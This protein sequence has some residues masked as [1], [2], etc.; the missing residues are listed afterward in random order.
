V[1]GRL[2]EKGFADCLAGVCD[3]IDIRSM[4]AELRERRAADLSA[5]EVAELRKWAQR[6]GERGYGGAF[7]PVLTAIYKVLAAQKES[8]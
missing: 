1:S 7:L 8:K 6:T 5:E 3:K 4:I 2:T